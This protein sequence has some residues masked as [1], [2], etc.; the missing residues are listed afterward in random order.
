[1]AFIPEL[2]VIAAFTLAAWLLAA[3]PGPDM[4]L[5]LS[6]T[7][8]SGRAAGLMSLAGAS[9]GTLVHTTL[10]VLG[11]SAII[12]ASATAFTVLKLAGAAYLLWL[13]IEALWKGSSFTPPDG[14]ERKAV[15]LKRAFLSG[16]GINLLNPKIVLFFMTFLPQFVSAADPAAAQ[17]MAFLGVLF[18][19]VCAPPLVVLIFA[20]ERFSAALARNPKIARVIDYLFAS[21]FAVFAVRILLE[22]GS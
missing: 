8:S 1:M 20:A 10:A 17:K 19:V 12:A 7:L 3:T 5:F 13:A 18:V 6:R 4:T 11:V 15:T 9:T 22:E 21:V 16:I 14:G 2:S